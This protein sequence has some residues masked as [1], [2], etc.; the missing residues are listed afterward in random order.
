MLSSMQI[1]SLLKTAPAHE[2]LSPKQIVTMWNKESRGGIEKHLFPE[3]QSTC[4]VAGTYLYICQPCFVTEYWSLVIYIW[5][6]FHNLGYAMIFF[7]R[8]LWW[9]PFLLAGPAVSQTLQPITSK[10]C[11]S[12]IRIH[13]YL[14]CE[15]I[16]NRQIQDSV[17]KDLPARV[18][19]SVHRFNVKWV[20]A[21]FGI[22]PFL[23]MK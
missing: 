10:T 21:D 3:E 5:A 12:E 1:Q 19:I 7:V 14:K 20:R 18:K 16:S 4:F 22:N 23:V 2:A 15:K 6:L 17:Q 11:D 8:M 9:L 13:L